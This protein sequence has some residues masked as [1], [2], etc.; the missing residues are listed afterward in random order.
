MTHFDTKVMVMLKPICRC[1]P[2]VG[3]TQLAFFHLNDFITN[4][5]QDLY[6]LR[7]TSINGKLAAYM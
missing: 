5:L 2:S 3:Q 6:Y 4:T 7:Y 1:R